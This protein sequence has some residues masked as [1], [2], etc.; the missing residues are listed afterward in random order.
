MTIM[1]TKQLKRLPVGMLRPHP[2][3]H[4][5]SSLPSQRP[6]TQNLSKIQESSFLGIKRE[7]WCSIQKERMVAKTHQPHIM[8]LLE[9]VR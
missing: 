5:G 6:W 2:P 7:K 9:L 4:R 1:E 8:G 3:A